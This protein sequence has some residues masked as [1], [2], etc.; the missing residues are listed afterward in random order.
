MCFRFSFIMFFFLLF[1]WFC[2]CS[3]PSSLF[4]IPHLVLLLLLAVMCH[5]LPCVIV[6]C[7]GALPSTCFAIVVHYDSLSLALCCY[8]LL[9]WVVLPY[10]VVLI[11]IHCSSPYIVTLLLY[12]SSRYPP[13][14]PLCCYCCLLGFVTICLASLLFAC[15]GDASLPP[16]PLA[17]CKF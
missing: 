3:L 1:F 15:W 2:I 17:M 13:H 7:C 10:V 5:S 8:C 6:T 9:W 11:V 14:L 4:V 12:A 16:P